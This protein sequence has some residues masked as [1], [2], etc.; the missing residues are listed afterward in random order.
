MDQ[1]SAIEAAARFIRQHDG[2]TDHVRLEAEEFPGGWLVYVL[3]TQ[4]GMPVGGVNLVVDR[5]DGSVRSVGS[6]LDPG[7]VIADYRRFRAMTPPEQAGPSPG[8]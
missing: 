7:L 2:R 5:D 8:S 6:D 1:T 3:P 4:T